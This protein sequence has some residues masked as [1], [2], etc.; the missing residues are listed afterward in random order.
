VK[1]KKM[2][3]LISIVMVLLIGV[4][5]ISYAAT[6]Y[7]SP[8]EIIAALTG[9]SVD[10]VIAARQAGTSLGAQALDAGKLEEFQ[11]AKLELYKQRLDQAVAEKRMT[12]EDANQLFDAMKLKIQECTGDRIGQGAGNRIGNG[13]AKGSRS[14][15]GWETGSRGMAWGGGNS[16]R[17]GNGCANCTGSSGN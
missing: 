4:T 5:S 6:V 7:G 14:G 15:N 9:N 13:F 8:A 1:K 12:Q 2:V 10:E 16:A 11:A 3:L 17:S